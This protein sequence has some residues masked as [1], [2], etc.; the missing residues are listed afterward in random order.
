MPNTRNLGRYGKTRSGHPK[1]IEQDGM[2][3]IHC[4]VC[5]TRAGYP[6][7][8]PADQFGSNAGKPY[9]VKSMCKTCEQKRYRP[10]DTEKKPDPNTGP[11]IHPFWSI[12]EYFPVELTQQIQQFLE[13][14]DRARR[15][16]S[17]YPSS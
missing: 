6:V 2:L 4:C 7:Y 12:F 3:L 8:Y 10:R 9:G 14:S 17:G 15:E 1:V 16:C 11:R 13:E 5:S